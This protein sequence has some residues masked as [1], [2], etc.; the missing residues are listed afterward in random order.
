MPNDVSTLIV[1]SEPVLIGSDISKFAASSKKTCA[2]HVGLK[3]SM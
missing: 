1:I 3:M 2:V